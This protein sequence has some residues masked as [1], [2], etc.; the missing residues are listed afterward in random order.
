MSFALEAF[1]SVPLVPPEELLDAALGTAGTILAKGPLAVRL[2]KLVVRGGAETDQRT[3][4]LLERLAQSLLYAADEKAEG[5][6]AFVKDFGVPDSS[7]NIDFELFPQKRHFELGVV[8]GI[9]NL[10]I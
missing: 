2:A 3:G 8:R 9:A 7:S 10:S 5:A 1:A 6:S 4:L